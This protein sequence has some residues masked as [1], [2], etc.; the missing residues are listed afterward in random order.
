MQYAGDASADRRADDPEL[1]IVTFA[2]EPPDR[3]RIV[4]L[5]GQH[6]R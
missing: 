6:R 5:L 2:P 3:D 1:G 4:A